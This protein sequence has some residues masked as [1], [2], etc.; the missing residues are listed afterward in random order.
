MAVKFPIFPVSL[1]VF[2][3]TITDWQLQLSKPT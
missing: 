2:Q 3:F 1:L